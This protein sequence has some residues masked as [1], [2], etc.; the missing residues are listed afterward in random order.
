MVPVQSQPSEPVLQVALLGSAKVSQVFPPKH[1]VGI[2]ALIEPLCVRST[3]NVPSAPNS[4]LPERSVAASIM[5]VG[6]LLTRSLLEL[7]SSTQPALIVHLPAKLPPHAL[8]EQSTGPVV[9]FESNHEEREMRDGRSDRVTGDR[10]VQILP[11]VRAG[12]EPRNH[13][14]LARSRL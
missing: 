11:S 2:A 14:R 4:T 5:A 1:E 6:Q 10:S 9:P 12:I 13:G 3:L 8:N 7:E